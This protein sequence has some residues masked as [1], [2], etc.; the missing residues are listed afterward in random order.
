MKL[1]TGNHLDEMSNAAGKPQD[2]GSVTSEPRSLSVWVQWRHLDST[3]K[4]QYWDLMLE[5][6]GKMVSG[7]E[8][9]EYH[10]ET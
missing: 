7:G 2:P 3:Q 1:L 8:T 4:E 10:K 6:Y 5:T 9:Q